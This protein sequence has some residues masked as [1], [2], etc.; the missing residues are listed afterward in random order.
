M[1]TPSSYAFPSLGLMDYCQEKTA[2]SSL[3]KSIMKL[4]D[5][6]R[7]FV[8]ECVP[9]LVCTMAQFIMSTKVN[10]VLNFTVTIHT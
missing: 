2:K 3:I 7:L 4:K 9:V 8:E 5:C 1:A 10:N 6:R